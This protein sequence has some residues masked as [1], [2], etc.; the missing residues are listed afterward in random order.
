MPGRRRAMKKCNNLLLIF[1]LMFTLTACSSQS[2]PPAST[3]LAKSTTA[4]SSTEQNLYSNVKLG[5]SF[6]I[7]DSWEPENY[8]PTIKSSKMNDGTKY[9]KVDFVFQDDKENPLLSIQ[10]VPKTWW[11]KAKNSKSTNTDY[12]GTKNDLVY[13][14]TLPQACPYEVGKKAD[15]YNSMTLLNNDVP[16]RFKII[17]MAVS[18]SGES[19]DTMQSSSK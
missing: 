12:L 18:T 15:L 3:R 8:A 5:F 14:F 11:D 1:L 17:E 16:N 9:T 19:L 13:I 7:P 10:I 6:A 2:P 4:A